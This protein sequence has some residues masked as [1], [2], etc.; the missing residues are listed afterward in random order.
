MSNYEFSPDECLLCGQKYSKPSVAISQQQREHLFSKAH[1]QKLIQFVTNIAVENGVSPSELSA[2]KLFASAETSNNNSRGSQGKLLTS[3][4]DDNENV[5]N[6][7]D[8]DDEF[9]DEEEL[10]NTDLETTNS[11]D[12]DLNGA[13]NNEIESSS[14]ATTQ[15]AEIKAKQG[16]NTSS[17]A[18][19]DLNRI[20]G[21]FPK[22]PSGSAAEYSQSTANGNNIYNYL[23]YSNLLN[24]KAASSASSVSSS[25]S[26]SSSSTT[27]S[28]FYS[29]QNNA[30]ALA[31]IYAQLANAS[32]SNNQTES[33]YT[34]DS[35]SLPKNVQYDI[36]KSLNLSFSALPS[37]TS[38][39][40]I[41]YTL[42]G[43]KIGE[44]RSKYGL[45]RSDLDE[46]VINK[47]YVCRLCKQ[48]TLTR[49]QLISH[50]CV[51]QISNLV[52]NQL[53]IFKLE[54]IGYK[55]GK[56]T[57]I[58]S[59]NFSE[60][61]EHSIKLEHFKQ[62]S[63]KRKEEDVAEDED[64]DGDGEGDG[65]NDQDETSSAKRFKY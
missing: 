14:Q 62:E 48:V 33:S 27:T 56:C 64:G 45:S 7:F 49:E 1:L 30:V 41:Q 18:Q 36:E 39:N 12:D 16:G 28:P 43:N 59:G 61:L 21:S 31:Q 34:L 37:P 57:E 53:N 58:V 51:N 35:L 29:Q 54:H 63:L 24:N 20:L 47:C 5:I 26:S 6:H 4:D 32:G 52:A 65:E 46:Q 3:P 15:T 25:S 10:N 50:N 11:E 13:N 38:N 23:L 44:I 17:E 55:C 60:F 9:V 8:D 2:G 22:L 42:D 40:T 19:F